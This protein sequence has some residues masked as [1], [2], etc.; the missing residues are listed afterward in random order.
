MDTGCYFGVTAMPFDRFFRPS[1][2]LLP[3]YQ[4]KKVQVKTE[5]PANQIQAQPNDKPLEFVAFCSTRGTSLKPIVKAIEEKRLNAK[6]LCV[7]SNDPNAPA[8]TFAREHGIET[9]VIEERYPAAARIR[10]TQD[11][12]LGSFVSDEIPGRRK[13]REEF[14]TEVLKVLAAKQPDLNLF[15]GYMRIV[16]K[17]FVD[18]WGKRT[19]NTHPSLLPDFAG[20]M[21]EEVH[22][23]V[24]ASNVT[25]SGCTIHEVTADVDAGPIRKQLKT[26]VYRND[27]RHPEI[28]PDTI[29]TLK[30]RVQ[31]SESVGFME[32]IAEELAKKKLQASAQ[33]AVAVAAGFVEPVIEHRD[34]P[35]CPTL[36]LRRF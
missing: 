2:L 10:F 33:T 29:Q 9:V 17:Q 12:F 28:P 19:L 8:L 22:K 25:E 23:A 26:P 36:G 35:Y 5:T 24:L 32:I 21:N 7:I 4:Q 11:H 16:S 20:G 30:D 3:S 6:V 31:A 18:A 1:S 13:T 34:V 14:D 27:G 15:I